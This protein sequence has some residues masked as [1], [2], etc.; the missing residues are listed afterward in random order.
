MIVEFTI[1]NFWSFKERRTFSLLATKDNELSE[2]NTIESSKKLRFL[3]SAVLY[4]A[5]ASG[6]SNFFRALVFFLNFSVFSGPNK[7]VGDT[8][9][10]T[11]FALSKQTISAPSFFELVF[12]IMD[13][14]E[15]TRYRYGFA[16]DNKQVIT[17]HL[18]AVHKV[19][20]VMLFSRDFQEIN[21]T[22]YFKEGIRGKP[23]VRSNSSFLSICAQGNGKISTEIIRYFRNVRVSSG[24]NEQALSSQRRT[25][26]INYKEKILG[27]L[28]Y[29]DI[30]ITDYKTEHVPAFSKPLES[31][32]LTFLKNKFPSFQKEQILEERVS[33]GHI[34]H[35][36]EIPVGELYLD[37][38]QESDGTRKLFSY[39]SDIL[40][41]L[42]KGTS[43]FIDEFDTKLHPLLIERI[44]KLFNSPIT[45]QKNAQL[46]ISC[47]AVNIMT[48]KLFRRDQIW[49]CEKDEYGATD[50]Y[51]LV[52]YKEPVRKDTLFNK[53]YLQGKYGAVPYLSEF[54]PKFGSE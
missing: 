43:L 3:K 12:I 25:S 28:K 40:E 10:T 30:Q 11:P 16:V 36:G 21:H 37:E 42:E 49:F 22:S 8:I 19:K 34:V 14:T 31:D 13:G 15:E 2:S 52:E 45:N 5:N 54:F 17:E 46:I 20:E 18:F 33:Y 38:T 29:A 39:S 27:F 48:N 35:D 6:K 47:H 9:E 53:N 26:Q 4:G 41:V 23:F 44:V 7:Q 51:S 50:L 32:L 24:L 1:E